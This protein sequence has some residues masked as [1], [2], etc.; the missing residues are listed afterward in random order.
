MLFMLSSFIKKQRRVYGISRT[1][2]SN[3]GDKWSANE[4][5]KYFFSIRYF[6][7]PVV[8]AMIMS[9]VSAAL[10]IPIVDLLYYNSRLNYYTVHKSLFYSPT[11]ETWRMIVFTFF[12]R[13]SSHFYVIV[14]RI[15]ASIY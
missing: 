13:L 12:Q 6:T 14:S 4:F 15:R 8:K 10:L 1:S 9:I 3:D 7:A 2:V 11:E 5:F